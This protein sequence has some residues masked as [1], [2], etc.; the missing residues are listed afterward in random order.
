MSGMHYALFAGNCVI[1]FSA[2]MEPTTTMAI[3]PQILLNQMQPAR[4]IFIQ[5]SN[6][7]WTNPIRL[8][9]N[10]LSV[11]EWTLWKRLSVP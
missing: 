11:M 1:I 3:F 5:Q 6:I 2:P 8:I 4:Q 7:Q 10:P 9:M